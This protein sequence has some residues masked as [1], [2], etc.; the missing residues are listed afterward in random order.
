MLVISYMAG[1]IVSVIVPV[2]KVE[3]FIDRCASSLFEQTM[4]IGVEFIF[5]DDASPD[6]SIKIL[7]QCL[8]R[9][10]NRVGQ[11]K[12]LKHDENK[13]LPAARNTG[14]AAATGRYVL[15]C[16][17][18]DYVEHD[19]LQQLVL[20][21]EQTGAD[22]VWC[23]WF[24]TFGRNE[25][26]MRQPDYDTPIEALKGMLAGV[27]KFNVWNKLVRR[28]LYVDN[29]ISFPAG[30]GM[31]EDM[32]MMLLFACANRV[33]YLPKAFY[34]Y[35]RLNSG[36]FCNTYSE[37]HLAELYH[38]VGDVV[39]KLFAMLGTGIVDKEVEYF[40][41]EAKFPFLLS[42]IKGKY[43]LWQKWF[44]ESNAYIVSNKYITIRRKALQ[45]LAWKRQYWLIEL[46]Y[47]FVHKLIYGVI[48]K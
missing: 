1:N 11:V 10:P 21:A 3:N 34:H 29:D 36:A 9:Y 7:Q 27:M 20:T 26:H 37:R 2:Y 31:G 40:K 5:V 18:D 39:N 16:D 46:Y 4:C 8:E 25:R 17:S 38:N 15:H 43:K 12:V 30:Y 6:G 42:E 44:P 13:G 32:T 48:F 45:W 41:Q 22:V 14:L 19:M 35:V 24:L 23:D 28:S 33:I 47:H